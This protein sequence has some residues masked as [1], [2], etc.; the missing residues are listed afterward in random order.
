MSAYETPPIRHR[1]ICHADKV[2]IPWKKLTA[3]LATRPMMPSAIVGT[4]AFLTSLARMYL[5]TTL[6]IAQRK[7][8]MMDNAIHVICVRST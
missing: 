5:S 2:S 6:E 7:E 8:A 3:T 4:I 1:M